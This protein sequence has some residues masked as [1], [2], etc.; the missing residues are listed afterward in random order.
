LQWILVIDTSEQVRTRPADYS[1]QKKFYSGKKKNHTLKNQLIVLPDGSD[2]VDV[3]IGKPGPSSDINLFRERQVE[4]AATQKFK[5]DLGYLGENPIETP[6]KKPKFN[7]L[8][9]E[10]KQQNKEIST[11]RIIIEH[12][13][14]LLKI[15]RIAQERFRL[16]SK[17][18]DQVIQIVCGLVRL[19]IGALNLQM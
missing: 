16:N 4:F 8:S 3:T 14:R 1:K 6:H 7:K 10:Q 19:R 18:Y 5:A 12:I 11:Q 2:I 17:H 15:F 13:I 9:S